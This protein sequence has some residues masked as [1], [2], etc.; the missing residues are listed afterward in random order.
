MTKRS[1]Y[2]NVKVVVFGITFDSIKESN[3]YLKLRQQE[4]DGE[5]SNLEL[6]PRFDC[7]VN[8]VHVCF[9]KA[10][11]KYFIN[12]RLV[13]EDV[14]SAFTAKNREFRLKKKLVE[15]LHPC[16]AIEIVI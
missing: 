7:V 14:K 16:I 2:G 4:K 3:R 8:G 9:Y 11:F 12:D 6:Q 13:V 5:I 1:K 15:A 10:D